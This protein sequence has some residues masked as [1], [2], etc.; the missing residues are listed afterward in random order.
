MCSTRELKIAKALALARKQLRL[1]KSDNLGVRFWLPVL[2]AVKKEVAAADKA[3][4]KMAEEGYMSVDTDL[5]RSIC[6]Y[7][8]KRHEE[9]AEYLYRAILQ[10]PPLRHIVD[11][12]DAKFLHALDDKITRRLIT[13]DYLLLSDLFVC[14][15][16]FFRE[17][18]AEFVMLINLPEFKIV[19]EKVAKVF[20]A[21]WRVPGGTVENWET[22]IKQNAALLAHVR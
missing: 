11:F 3:C 14:A 10:F 20:F 7:A 21:N 4:D 13:P 19:E 16:I 12:D 17:M 5:I 1:N 8:N 6:H 18:D 15:L 9:A 2:L 22:S